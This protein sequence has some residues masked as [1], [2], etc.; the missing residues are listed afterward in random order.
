MVCITLQ[1]LSMC[2]G[3]ISALGIS[4]GAVPFSMNL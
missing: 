2:D 4:E 3:E 1:P